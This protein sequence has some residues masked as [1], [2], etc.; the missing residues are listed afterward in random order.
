MLFVI[1]AENGFTLLNNYFELQERDASMCLRRTV[2]FTMIIFLAEQ[3]RRRT[4][5][6]GNYR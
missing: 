6:R 5:E 3:R 2:I 1:F 4:S